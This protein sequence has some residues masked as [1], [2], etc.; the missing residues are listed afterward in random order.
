M[1]ARDDEQPPSASRWWRQ[2]RPEDDEHAHAYDVV[3]LHARIDALANLVFD[4][5]IEVRS[6]TATATNIVNHDQTTTPADDTHPTTVCY[7]HQR[8]GDHAVSCR[9]P[10]SKRKKQSI[11]KP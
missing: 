2:L 1:S 3:A 10:C 6:M 5:Q 11:L 8:Y 4:L 7:Y 9:P